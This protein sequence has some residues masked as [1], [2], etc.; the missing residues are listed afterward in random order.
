MSVS[1][2]QIVVIVVVVA[3]VVAAVIRWPDI[4]PIPGDEDV[5]EKDEE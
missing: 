1:A 5:I 2:E 3:L 4:A